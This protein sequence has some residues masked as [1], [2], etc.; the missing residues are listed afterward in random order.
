MVRVP[1]LKIECGLLG[2]APCGALQRSP[3]SILPGP[4]RVDERAGH[5]ALDGGV[6]VGV[7]EDDERRL[8]AQFQ[9]HPLGGP[10]ALAMTFLPTALEP[11][12]DTMSTPGCPIRA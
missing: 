2:D 7:G 3:H 11:V 4:P 9:M 12:K 10:G 5:R 1:G 8:A 6:L